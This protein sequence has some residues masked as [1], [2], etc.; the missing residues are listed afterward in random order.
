LDIFEN[1][2]KFQKVEIFEKMDSYGKVDIFGKM[3]FYGKVA[4]LQF[5]PTS[6]SDLKWSSNCQI[7]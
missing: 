2:E 4:I 1:W 7:I 5:V 6:K 3:D